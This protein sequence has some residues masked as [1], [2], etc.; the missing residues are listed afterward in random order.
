MSK[1]RRPW[2]VPAV[3]ATM[4]VTFAPGVHAEVLHEEPFTESYEYDSSDC[5]FPVHVEGE[6]TVAASWRVGKNTDASIHF[7]REIVSVREVHTNPANGKWFVVSGHD[8]FREVNA[9]HVDGNIYEITQVLAGQP[10]V[11]T[12]SSGQVVARDRGSIHIRMLFDTGGDTDPARQFAG[13]SGF[14]V[15]GPH[16]TDLCASVGDAGRHQPIVPALQPPPT[17]HDRIADGVRRV[18]PAQLRPD[19]AQPVAGV[20]ARQR[21]R[22]RRF[23]RPAAGTRQ[24]CHPR[25]HRP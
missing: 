9:T 6:V 7:Y 20:P 21:R 12:D 2:I 18:P 5:G 3:A 24:S 13:F 15:H 25:L 23:G 4:L 10:T 1:P 16:D 8:T 22:R 11:I 19:R 14:E 17:R